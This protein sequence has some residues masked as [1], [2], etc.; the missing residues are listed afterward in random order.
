MA[1][2]ACRRGRLF[3]NRG[4][5]PLHRFGEVAHPPAFVETRIVIAADALL[6]SGGGANVGC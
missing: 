1:D 2:R 5:E 4:G 3:D 6:A